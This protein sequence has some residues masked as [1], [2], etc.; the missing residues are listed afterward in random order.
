MRVSSQ[1][2]SSDMIYDHYSFLVNVDT[3]V[4]VGANG[5]N[6]IVAMYSTP[7]RAK[8]ALDCLVNMYRRHLQSP[9]EEM[10]KRYIFPTDEDFKREGN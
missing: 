3:V 9:K 10:Y 2:N 5:E 7:K 6:R 4:A 8:L 1:D